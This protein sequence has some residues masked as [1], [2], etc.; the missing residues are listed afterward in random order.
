MYKIPVEI[1]K[2]I[3]L[4]SNLYSHYFQDDVTGFIYLGLSG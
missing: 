1:I 3:L 2:I 4:G